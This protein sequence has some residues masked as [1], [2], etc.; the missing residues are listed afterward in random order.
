MLVVRRLLPLPVFTS[1]QLPS[2]SIALQTCIRWICHH[3]I[4]R[5]TAIIPSLGALAKALVGFYG[6]GFLLNIWRAGKSQIIKYRHVLREYFHLGGTRGCPSVAASP[7]SNYIKTSPQRSWV[8]GVRRKS[9]IPS[10]NLY[11]HPALFLCKL[12]VSSFWF[13]VLDDN[14][15]HLSIFFTFAQNTQFKL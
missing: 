1:R 7:S 15:K 3:R 4:L 8:L 9:G 10:T 2:S 14:S 5:R 13:R 12:Q 11:P 6:G